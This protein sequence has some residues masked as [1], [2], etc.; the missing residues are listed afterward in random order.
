MPPSEK[1]PKYVCL[2][3]EKEV[4]IKNLE[5]SLHEFRLSEGWQ[6]QTDVFR[7][8]DIVEFLFLAE[9]QENPKLYEKYALKKIK[10]DFTFEEIS[11]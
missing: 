6:Q 1:E 4:N 9:G 2:K 3:L 11:R 10:K 8:K 7:W 5:N